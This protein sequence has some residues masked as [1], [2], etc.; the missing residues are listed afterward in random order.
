MRR[1]VFTIAGVASLALWVT[2][3]T[4]ARGGPP[5]PYGDPAG[6]ALLAHVH[7]AYVGVPAVAISGRTGSFSFRFTLVLRSGIGVAEQFVGRGATGT[8][9]LVQRRRSPTFAREPGTSCWRALPAADPQSFE[10]IGLR[11]PDQAGMRVGA[12]RR[13]SNGWLL[14]VS[15][16][17][18]PATFA[19]QGGSMLI[20][21]ITINAQQGRRLIEHVSILHSAPRLLT[22]EPR[23]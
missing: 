17:R 3:A 10:N 13:T 8:T 21:S 14:P 22:P 9:L 7:R 2:A 12:P 20:R 11:F 16:D 19:I 5:P 4:N 23:C 18:E 6:L 1:A 15:I